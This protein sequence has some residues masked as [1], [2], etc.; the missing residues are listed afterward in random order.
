MLRGRLHG[1]AGNREAHAGQQDGWKPLHGDADAE[2]GRTP[3]DV[4]EGEREDDLKPT[5]DR[6]PPE[7]TSMATR[8]RGVPRN[9]RSSIPNGASGRSPRWVSTAP[10]SFC[11]RPDWPA[12]SS[13]RRRLARSAGGRARQP[14]CLCDESAASSRAARG[15]RSSRTGHLSAY[16]TTAPATT[17]SRK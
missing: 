12:R 15:G 16:W 10:R 3:E 5:A 13:K 7:A 14:S 4:D 11:T 2:V 9:G 1:G 8:G 17:S 6:A